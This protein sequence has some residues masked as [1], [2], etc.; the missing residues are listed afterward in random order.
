M[1]PTAVPNKHALGRK[2]GKHG[3]KLAFIAGFCP[4]KIPQFIEP[5]HQLD[6]VDEIVLYTR[7]EFKSASLPKLRWAGMPMNIGD[8]VAAELLRG[9]KIFSSISDCDIIIGCHQ[10]YH[11][12]WAAAAGKLYGKPVIQ[13]IITD[14][15]RVMGSFIRKISVLSSAAACVMG[16][17]SREK[18]KTYG[19]QRLI[20]EVYLPNNFASKDITCGK[21]DERI[22]DLVA[23]GHY[24]F[25]KDYP[26][27]MKVFSE[28]K[29]N[30]PD[31]RCAVAGRGH[32]ITRRLAE[33]CGL[34]ENLEFKGDI[35]KS[36]L[37]RLYKQSRA[38][39]LCSKIEG[40]PM[41]LVEAMS[42]GLP[43]F[44]TAVGDVPWLIRDGV[45]GRIV[46][47]GDTSS[48][49]LAILDS[50][51]NIAELDKMSSNARRRFD[52]LQPC[53]ADTSMTSDAWRRLLVSCEGNTILEN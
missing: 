31:F 34:G 45:E 50:L 35:G 12:V 9:V 13:M 36:E 15:D 16:P 17:V 6:E 28:L 52:E 25:Q 44:A 41:V 48:M 14:V 37:S 3:K 49:C 4:V 47:H 1:E 22:F 40:L 51:R 27:M 23:V 11:G 42:F 8:G 32:E 43:V 38:I 21:P 7:R 2:K 18:L 53:F 29:R 39:I 10:F 33:E 24:A 19:Y 46:A 26:W 5:L 20:E 30:Y